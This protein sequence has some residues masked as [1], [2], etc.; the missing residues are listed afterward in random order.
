MKVLF[1]VLVADKVYSLICELI[2]W[3]SFLLSFIY[4]L[5]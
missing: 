5:E 4:F 1:T 2:S 3:G